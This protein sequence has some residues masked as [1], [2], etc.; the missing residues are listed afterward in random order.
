MSSAP[1]PPGFKKEPHKEA[2]FGN[3]GLRGLYSNLISSYTFML[4]HVSIV[5]SFLPLGIIP[6]YGYTAIY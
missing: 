2:D 4:Q 5:H 1:V 6:L 3:P